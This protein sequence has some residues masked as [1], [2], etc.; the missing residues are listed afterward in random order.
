VLIRDGP[1]PCLGG[2][3]GAPEG[4]APEAL[5]P[6]PLAVPSPFAACAGGANTLCLLNGRFQVQAEYRDY[7]GNHGTASAV[8]IT[9]DTGYFWFFD[10]ANVEAVVKMVSF[11]SGSSGNVG[12]YAGGLTDIEVKLKV[13]DTLF[14]TYREYTN[15]LGTGWHLIK[16]GPFVCP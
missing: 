11:C 3:D 1:F 15:P 14:G 9:A 6:G 16:D 13:L 12:M 8:A 10:S 4:P 7:A 2:R 5:P